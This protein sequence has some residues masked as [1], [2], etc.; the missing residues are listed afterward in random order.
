MPERDPLIELPVLFKRLIKRMTQEWNKLISEDLTMS[1]SRMLYMLSINGPMKAIEM[2]E[3]LDVTAGAI[4]GMT[5]KLVDHGW[6][7]RTRNEDDRR[8]VR[9]QLTE[10]GQL[11]V[12]TLK[13]RQRE[14]AEA[15][16]SHLP[17]EDIDNLH[18]IF[19]QI[20]GQI[21]HPEEEK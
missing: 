18:R 9:L 6:V 8:V 10:K 16:F 14:I 4:T 13:V 2:S 3:L 17:D 15:L 19:T 12:G 1:Q 7:E 11:Y 20:L 5:D 21:E